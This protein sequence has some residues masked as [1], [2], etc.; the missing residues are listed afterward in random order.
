MSEPDYEERLLKAAAD[1]LTQQFGSS[2]GLCGC[3]TLYVAIIEG[4][5]ALKCAG[6]YAEAIDRSSYK[7]TNVELAL[8]A[9][10]DL[11]QF[12]STEERIRQQSN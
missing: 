4:C 7:A 11:V 2:C 8:E 9:G 12:E 6:C 10:C 3:P 5:F 1:K